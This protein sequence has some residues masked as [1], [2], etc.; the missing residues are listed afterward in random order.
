YCRKKVASWSDSVRKQLD[1][2][3][4]DLFPAVL[5]YRLSIDRR[6]LGQMKERTLCNS[7]S[8]LRAYL[9]EH[10]TAEQHVPAHLPQI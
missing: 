3:H 4:Q 1:P 8:R 2:S 10:H 7:S 9:V 5:T 6:V